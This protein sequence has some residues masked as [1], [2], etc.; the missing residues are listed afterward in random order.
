MNDIAAG[1]PLDILAPKA[2]PI[3]CVP[4]IMDLRLPP[5][6]G[7]MTGRLPSAARIILS[8]CRLRCRRPPRRCDL[9]A[10]RERKAQRSQPAALYRRRARP[11]RRPS[12]ATHC[13][14]LALELAAR[15]RYPRRR[16]SRPARGALR[17]AETFWG[18]IDEERSAYFVGISRAKNR[19][20]LTVCDHRDRPE[21]AQRWT[22]ERRPHAEFLG[23]RRP[24]P[25]LIFKAQYG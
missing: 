3:E 20:L 25:D 1:A 23:L 12:G 13:R 17:E 7:R 10:D 6:M 14:P 4:A 19:L 11:H 16:L 18:K 15:R 9:L 24:I 22:P 21:G 5:D 2:A 8:V